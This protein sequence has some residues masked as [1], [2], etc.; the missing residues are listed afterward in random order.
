MDR[1]YRTYRFEFNALGS[2]MRPVAAHALP[3]RHRT[4]ANESSDRDKRR[5][6]TACDNCGRPQFYDA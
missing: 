4:P 1:P 6:V 2:R 3:I 5:R